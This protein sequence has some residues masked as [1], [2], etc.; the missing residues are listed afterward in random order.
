[1]HSPVI[2]W[3]RQ[4]LRLTDHATLIAAA[5]LGPVIF[6][7][8]LDDDTPGEWR[9]GA[10]SRWWLHKSLE[11]LGQRLPLLLRRGAADKVVAGILEET[12]ARAVCFTRDY[13]PWS[14]ALE[15]RVKQACEARGAACHRYGGY[16]LHEP[17]T[18][19]NGSGDPYRVYTPFS[20][21]CFAAGEPKALKPIPAFTLWDGQIASDNLD[22]WHL[23]PVKPNWASAMEHHWTPGETGAG[24]RLRAF[25]EDDLKDYAAARD[26]PGRDVTS[27][28]FPHLHFGEISPAQCWHGWALPQ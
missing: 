4:D 14:A 10:A 5:G 18:I 17:E 2:V 16:L 28:L 23:A 26:L 1:M 27:R 19:R 7:Y 21:A 9:M 15:R 24:K 6:L 13:A 22:E 12:G 25:I 8:V 3:L 20:K 11:S